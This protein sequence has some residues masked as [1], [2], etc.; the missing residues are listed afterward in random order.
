MPEIAE[1]TENITQ[2]LAQEENQVEFPQ[3]DTLTN[4]TDIKEEINNKTID[5]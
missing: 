1:E 5:N 3:I 2:P 4:S